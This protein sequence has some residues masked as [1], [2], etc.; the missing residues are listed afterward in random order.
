MNFSKNLALWVVIGLLVFALFNL[1]QGS[2]SQREQQSAVAFSDF[3]A[4][5]DSNEIRDVTIVGQTITGHYRDGRK[6][7]T[8]APNDPG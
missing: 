6:F 1:F 4:S 2:S 5:V 3:L 8:Y 7:G